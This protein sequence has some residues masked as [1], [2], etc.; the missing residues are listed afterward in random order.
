MNEWMRMHKRIVLTFALLAMVG[1]GFYGVMYLVKGGGSE[2]RGPGGAYFTLDGRRIT[3]EPEELFQER[4]LRWHMIRQGNNYPG[5]DALRNMAQVQMARDMGFEVGDQE[6]ISYEKA[7]IKQ[8]TKQPLVTEELFKNLLEDLQLTRNQFERLLRDAGTVHK[9]VSLFQEQAR[10]PEGEQYLSY[11]QR[12]QSVRIF[13]KVFSTKDYEE[14]AGDP[15]QSDIEQ[16]Y[17]KYTNPPEP[18]DPP[19]TE[20]D[21]LDSEPML[22]IDVLYF[23]KDVV[24]KEI[25]PTDEEVKKY[26]QDNRS[27]YRREPKAGQPIPTGEEA[28]KPFEE[29]KQDVLAACVRDALP[30]K[31]NEI[32][33]RLEK[34][35]AEAEKKA[36]ETRT[37][38]DLAAFAEK[39]GLTHWR[40]EKLRQRGFEKGSDAI[41]APDFRL[42]SD[43][44]LFRLAEKG[45]DDDAERKLAEDRKKFSGA[46]RI[47][48]NSPEDGFVMLRLAE[49][50]T[51]ALMKLEEATPVIRR[52][53]RQ[54]RAQKKA[55]EMAKEFM[56][57]WLKGDAVPKVSDLQEET[58]SSSVSAPVRNQIFADMLQRPKPVGELL[59]SSYQ[60]DAEVA[61]DHPDTR[62]GRYLVG[63]IAEREMPSPAS[64]ELDT[65]DREGGFMAQYQTMMRGRE[66]G[67][68]AEQFLYGY[69]G[70]E[71][72]KDTPELPLTSRGD[73]EPPPQ[74]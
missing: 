72:D 48:Y 67:Y 61:K 32:K 60:R 49:F 66:L 21:S 62:L 58:C 5:R 9:A 25:K 1:T 15:S 74:L 23:S 16:Y 8:R 7:N 2:G 29:V 65:L 20:A 37:K 14:L 43:P 10:V 54:D 11:C 53:L 35:I 33:A 70:I 13:F 68:E 57:K 51:K 40:T 56:D 34:E 55:E 39:Q 47:L 4:L 45:E 18:D 26:Y 30:V 41:K 27:F 3:V 59:I 12:K 17:K 46:R 50:Q 31:A 42:A 38:F 28:F 24:A 6:M 44:S 36:G 63:F 73:M 22:S 64:Y 19:R 69:Q 52:R 71:F